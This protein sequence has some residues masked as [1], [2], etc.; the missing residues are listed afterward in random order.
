M[1]PEML[2][3]M[4]ILHMTKGYN[5]SIIM[6]RE[7]V[8]SRK[9]GLFD[10]IK[11]DIDVN[12]NES[13]SSDL[14]FMSIGEK[15]YKVVIENAEKK[16]ED[17]CMTKATDIYGDVI[18]KFVLDRLGEEICMINKNGYACIYLVASDLAKY[19]RGEGYPVTC[20]GTLASSLVT[21]LCGISEVNPLPAHYYCPNCHHFELAKPVDSDDRLCGYELMAKKC[22]ECSYIMQSDGADIMHEI[23]MGIYMDK[24]PSVFLNFAPEIRSDIVKYIALKYSNCQVF[25]GGTKIEKEDGIVKRGVHPGA[26]YIVPGGVDISLYTTMREPRKDNDYLGLPI[27]EENYLKLDEHFKS[28]SILTQPELGMLHD[29]ENDTGFKYSDIPLN[30]NDV[31]RAFTDM[32]NLFME[33]F[34]ELYCNAVSILEPKCFSDIVKIE[35]LVHCSGNWE[36]NICEVI[37]DYSIDDIIVS[38]DDILHYL[39]SKDISKSEAYLIMSYIS[40]GKGLTDDVITIMKKAGVPRDYIVRCKHILY[41]YPLSQLIDYTL[42]NWRLA[43]YFLNYPDAYKNTYIRHLGE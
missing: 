13:D 7:K 16:L 35:G 24:E 21:F 11:T 28:Y 6:R 36:A 34:S 14:P 18:P 29:L 38:R 1:Q 9:M 31:I 32:P 2:V 8:G 40:K 5:S 17:I 22:P 4:I 30:D 39:L 26:V 20:R 19:S 41:L 15:N 42:V 23:N 12:N 33:K 3:H 25:I 10:E 37:R 27:S 43:Y